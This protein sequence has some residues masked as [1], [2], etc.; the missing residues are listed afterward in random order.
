[1]NLVVLKMK[2]RPL[3]QNDQRV[4]F[5]LQ[6]EH[7]LWVWHRKTSIEK[8]ID[9][10]R[11]SRRKSTELCGKDYQSVQNSHTARCTLEIAEPGIENTNWEVAG[12]VKRR[13]PWTKIRFVA[14]YRP[15]WLHSIWDFEMKRLS[16]LVIAA[17]LVCFSAFDGQLPY[18]QAQ[19]VAGSRVEILANSGKRALVANGKTFTIRGAGGD[20]SRQLLAQCG[21]NSIRTWGVDEK[22][23]AILDEAHQ[24]GLMVTLGIWLGHERH[25]FSYMNY[26]NVTE[27][28]DAV[29]DAVKKYKDHPAVL[30]WAL[31][32]EM[33]GYKDGDNP[34]IWSH[35]QALAS[36]VKHLDPHHPVMTV[37]AE[38]GGKRVEAIHRLCPAIDVVGINSYSGVSSIPKRYREA[39]G[40]KPYVVTEFG[41]P[42]IGEIPK[43]SFGAPEELSS[44]DKAEI[45]RSSWTTLSADDLC[46]GAYAFTWGF[47]QEATATWFG[48]LL[49]DGSRLGAVDSLA[50]V[51][52]G[53]RLP[54]LCPRISSLNVSANDKLKPGATLQASLDASDPD[55]DKL[56]VVW[57]FVDDPMN[58][59]SGGDAE[60]APDEFPKLLSQQT[61]ATVTVTMPE[62]GGVY[63][64]FVYVYDS[65]G[66]AAVANVP[67][68]VDGP[69][70]KSRPAP[71][72]KLPLIIA[73]EAHQ[74]FPFEPSDWMGN[75]ENIVM[76]DR[77]ATGSHSGSTC[78]KIQYTKPDGWGGVVWQN[79]PGDWGDRAGGYDLSGA[80]KL[81]FWARGER[82]GEK[83]KFGVGLIGDDKPYRDSMKIDAE[84]PLTQDWKQY[85]FKL[86]G[87]DL[88]RIKS[89]FFWTLAAQG[90]NVVFYLDDIQFE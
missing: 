74:K 27:Q 59:G 86:A 49:P 15:V 76:D 33:E 36:E 35:I 88:S 81:S 80:K 24:H 87:R 12:E 7:L 53:A 67:V 20:G 37:V 82:G 2:S 10:R 73:G 1:M 9:L 14:W 40:S 54:N 3:R 77:W 13:L 4:A 84:F 85:E 58:Y 52:R 69:K 23:K 16:I 22:T 44:T 68:F 47:K 25:G 75:R 63:R 43:N 56:K 26:R 61:D 70:R 18:A 32:N 83:V 29:R 79:P 65:H 30:M 90:E 6:L 11:Q 39:G 38:I 64:I 60:R 34:A 57:K 78:L 17:V 71:T 8:K 72:V 50:E 21:G 41:P 66:G 31:G 19:Q 51:W 42:G 46:L 45:Y 5:S 48:M 55:G 28:A 62:F 89:G